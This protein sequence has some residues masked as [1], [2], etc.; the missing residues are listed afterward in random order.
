MVKDDGYYGVKESSLDLFDE[1]EPG[2]HKSAEPPSKK[3][4]DEKSSAGAR[5]ADGQQIKRG[6][7]NPGETVQGHHRPGTDSNM[8]TVSRQTHQQASGTRQQQTAQQRAPQQRQARQAPQQRHNPGQRVPSRQKPAQSQ[9]L[10][11]EYD[12]NGGRKKKGGIFKIVLIVLLAVILLAG[13]GIVATKVLNGGTQEAQADEYS[14]S[15]RYAY[16]MLQNAL[17]EYNPEAID[18]VVGLEEGD[19]WLAQEWAYVNG[20]QLRQE[21]LKKVGAMIKFEYP[22]VAQMSTKGKPMTDKDGNQIMVDSY[23]NN[24]ESVTVQVPDYALLSETMKEEAEY[25]KRMYDS[26]LATAENTYRIHEDM[27]NLMM[28]YLC[29]KPTLPTKTAEFSLPVRLGVDG[30]PY[31]EDDAALD[32]LLFGSDEFHAMSEVFSQLAVGYTGYIEETYTEKEEQH[33]EEFDAWYEKF[34]VLYEADGGTYDPETHTFSGGKFTKG[35]SKWEPWYL[36]DDN[37]VI[38]VDENGEYIVNYFSIKDDAGNDWIQP[39]EII[40]V[41]VEK[42]RQIEDPWENESGIRYNHLG[43]HFIQTAYTGVGDRVFRVGDGSVTSPAG[44]GTPIITKALCSDGKYHDVEV[45]LIGYW[46]GED[47]INYS[48]QFSSRNRGFTTKSVVKLITFELTIKNLESED[49]TLDSEMT[50]CD[51]NANISSRT[52]TLYD[53]KNEGIVI[54]PGETVTVN[55]WAS[56]TELEQKYV[57]W[58]KS[59]GRQYSMVYFDCLAGT[60]IIPSYSAYEQFTGKG[61]VSSDTGAEVESGK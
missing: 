61:Q 47:A 23:M 59:F 6:Y 14:T 4:Y 32:D 55:D 38:Q 20:V 22:K 44:I 25:I 26:Y 29:D 2:T 58:G 18:A 24:G 45:A 16:D 21:F 52:G 51:K 8:Q 36:R 10:P 17:L 42:T 7:T 12:L 28:Q 46:I 5:V 60:G 54:R 33:N 50:L 43:V 13:V 39:D 19:S 48:E 40:L 9:Q 31:I 11:P 35:V 3:S 30:V 56:S 1:E 27:F 57:G 34:I 41:D 53:F 37:N 49:I 15:G